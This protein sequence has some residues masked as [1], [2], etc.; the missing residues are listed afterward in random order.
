[1]SVVYVVADPS[2]RVLQDGAAQFE[3]VSGLVSGLVSEQ[4]RYV[5][6]PLS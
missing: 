3:L 2:Q 4:S 5:Q 6:I 1:V